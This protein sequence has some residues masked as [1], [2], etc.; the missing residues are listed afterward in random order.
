MTYNFFSLALGISIRVCVSDTLHRFSYIFDI[1]CIFYDTGDIT[2]SPLLSNCSAPRISRT[3]AAKISRACTNSKNL[4]LLYIARLQDFYFVPR[5]YIEFLEQWENNGEKM[6]RGKIKRKRINN[7]LY[8][9]Q[10][11]KVSTRR[12]KSTHSTVIKSLQG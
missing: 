4:R 1:S 7:I 2:L 9:L 10:R 3:R 11:S 12:I 6:G 8:I 5:V